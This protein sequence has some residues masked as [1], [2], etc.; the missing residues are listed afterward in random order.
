MYIICEF[1]LVSRHMC[2]HLYVCSLYVLEND[3]NVQCISLGEKK[4]DFLHLTEI[5]RNNLE[6]WFVV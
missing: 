2:S 4:F 6:R 3:I 5:S 1:P